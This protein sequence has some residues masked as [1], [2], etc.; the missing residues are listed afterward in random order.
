VFWISPEYP[1]DLNVMGKVLPNSD[2][3]LNSYNQHSFSL[4]LM[5]SDGIWSGKE[6]IFTKGEHDETVH[7]YEDDSDQLQYSST[8]PYDEFEDSVN[9]ALR[10]CLRDDYTMEES[11]T[12]VCIGREVFPPAQR[13]LD[14]REVIRIYRDKLTSSLRNY[15]C[16]DHLLNTTAPRSTA[17]E[18]VR[19][20]EVRVDTHLDL[21]SA[22][23]FVVHDFVTEE[24][25]NTLITDAAP[26]L[27]RAAVVGDGG[28]ATFSES[29]RA[30]QA[31]YAIK[32]EEDP[33]WYI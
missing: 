20:R 21:D 24:E 11:E 31:G 27:E 2:F 9:E 4:R 28:Q 10:K 23:I 25:C 18:V 29:R 19:G 26:R 5:T 32:G 15:T 6:V 7:I 3:H 16:E 13:V 8:T 17:V 33:L 14:E 30:Q 22:K 12:R 1:Y